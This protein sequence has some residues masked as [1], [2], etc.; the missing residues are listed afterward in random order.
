VIE[1]LHEVMHEIEQT[2]ARK[3]LLVVGDVMLDKYIWGE[4][5][6]ISPEAPVPVVRATHQSEQPGGAANVAMNLARL[7]AQ[8]TVA[9]FTGGDD[10]ERLLAGNLRANGIEPGF[11]ISAGFPTITKLRILGGRQQMLRLD[12]ERQGVRAADD[13]MRLIQIVLEQLPGVDA[14]VLSDYAKGV[15]STEVCQQVI[16]AARRQGIPVLVDPKSADFGRYRGATTIWARCPGPKVSAGRGRGYGHLL[17]RRVSDRDSQRKG[18]C[19]GA[20]RQLLHCPG[21]GPPSLRCLRR[22]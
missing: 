13:Y 10:D 2:W 8:V 14:V 5:G 19:P 18:H 20:A 15:L 21:H 4:V 9:G 17:R 22:W 7:G 12:S 6:R 1:Q 11:V 3:R 16:A